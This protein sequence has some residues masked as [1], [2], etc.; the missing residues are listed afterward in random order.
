MMVTAASGIRNFSPICHSAAVMADFITNVRTTEIKP[1][2]GRPTADGFDVKKAMVASVA[3]SF[4]PKNVRVGYFS[5]DQSGGL[6]T[7]S[8]SAPDV[9]SEND[10]RGRSPEGPF[11]T[12]IESLGCLYISH[13]PNIMQPWEDACYLL[14]PNGYFDSI[15]LDFS[16]DRLEGYKTHEKRYTDSGRKMDILFGCL[17]AREQRQPLGVLR[18]D[19]FPFGDTLRPSSATPSELLERFGI[20]CEFASLGLSEWIYKMSQ[21]VKLGELQREVFAMVCRIKHDIG[22]ALTAPDGL[23]QLAESTIESGNYNMAIVFLKKA[24]KVLREKADRMGRYVDLAKDGRYALEVKKSPVNL[25][26]LFEQYR[27]LCKIEFTD[28]LPEEVIT[29]KS[30]VL[31]VLGELVV[32][33]KK[34]DSQDRPPRIVCQKADNEILISVIDSGAGLTQRELSIIFQGGYRGNSSNIEV[35]GSGQGLR[36]CR[37]IVHKLGGTIWAESEGLGKGAKFMFTLPI[38]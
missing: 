33:A 12:V 5:I 30:E 16:P 26:H 24:R 14:S 8:A 38:G 7:D 17:F 21:A 31:L 23:I 18:I 37:E 27:E 4:L 29:D 13:A 20:I 34:Y 36:E 3:K 1:D 11:R 6:H 9:F 15:R 32:N 19:A 25:K 35:P 28:D 10:L 22:S 2:S